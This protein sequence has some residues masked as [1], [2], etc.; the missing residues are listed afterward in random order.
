MSEEFS[1]CLAGL[2]YDGSQRYPESIISYGRHQYPV[3]PFPNIDLR[4]FQLAGENA[5]RPGM[6]PEEAKEQ[7]WV[8]DE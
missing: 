1:Q 7:I 3:I 5:L 8:I 2:T 6:T 4:V